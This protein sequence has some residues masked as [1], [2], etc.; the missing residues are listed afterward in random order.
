MRSMGRI[1]SDMNKE[2]ALII[3]SEMMCEFASRLV[4]VQDCEEY[5]ESMR[6]KIEAIKLGMF[7]I[8]TSKDLK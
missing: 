1:L 3:L 7:A 6:Q 4:L 2:E 8:Y 5:S